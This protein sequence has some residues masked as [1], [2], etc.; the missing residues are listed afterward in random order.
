MPD[1]HKKGAALVVIGC[2]F[3]ELDLS[4]EDEIVSKEDD[5]IFVSFSHS[6]NEVFIVHRHLVGA[7]RS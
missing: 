4:I 5:V 6:L 1:C 3:H 7:E 2:L